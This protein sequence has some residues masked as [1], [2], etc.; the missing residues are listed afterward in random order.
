[1][2]PSIGMAFNTIL[3]IDNAFL[4][5]LSADVRFA[6]LMTSITGVGLEAVGMTG[7]TAPIAVTVVHWEAMLTCIG[8]WFPCLCGVAVS[9]FGSEFSSMFFRLCMAGNTFG[10]RPFEYLIHMAGFAI[11]TFMRAC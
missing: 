2:F 11:C 4:H 5:M 3:K 8:S 9:A 10:R 7:L 6:V 1:M